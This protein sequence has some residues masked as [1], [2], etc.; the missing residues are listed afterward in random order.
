MAGVALAEEPPRSRAWALSHAF[1]RVG[2]LLTGDDLALLLR[3]S[4]DQ[5]ISRV[6]QWIARRQVVNFAWHAQFL[7]PVFQFEAVSLLPRPHVAA[8][9]AELKPV[10]DDWELAGWF[11]AP[12]DWLGDDSPAHVIATDPVAVLRAARAD[13]FVASC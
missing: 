3:P 2:G 8:V 12:N 6:A 4:V 10:Y 7:L 13:R 1:Q 5:P 9:I 11:A